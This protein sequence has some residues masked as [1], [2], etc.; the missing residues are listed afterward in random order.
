MVTRVFPDQV[1]VCRLLERCPQD[2]DDVANGFAAEW[3][4]TLCEVVDKALD[5]YPVQ[6]TQRDIPEPR[7][8][9]SG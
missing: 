1:K 2:N 3:R 9:G 5:R 7:D 4:I 8:E 6:R